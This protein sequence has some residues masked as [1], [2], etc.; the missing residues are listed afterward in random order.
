MKFGVCVQ[1][2]R[3][4]EI[5]SAGFDY[6]EI[7]AASL[8]GENSE[9]DLAPFRGLPI[10]ASNLFFPGPM[11]LYGPDATPYLAYAKRTIER[12]AQIGIKVMV[13]GSGGARRSAEG[14]DAEAR[15][16]D[17]A[18]ELNAVAAGYGIAVAPESLNHKETDV[19][20][21]MGRLAQDLRAHAVGFT[22][23]SYHLLV[24]WDAHFR[25][26]GDS[27]PSAEFWEHE[28]PF[29]PVHVHFANLPRTVP[30]PDD[31]MVKGFVA[32][33]HSLSYDGN[34]S[35]EC[36]IEARPDALREARQHLS[37]LFG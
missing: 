11:R 15:F 8:H 34:V 25:K 30:T 17:I 23:D 33:L 12:A 37:Q 24:D 22:A 4:D 9:F 27:E 13:L 5:L 32:R 1:P 35:L 31:V 28:I 21:K 2:D 26:P 6:I 3:A 18:A 10:L 20:N 29:T 36:T 19:G 7:A 14:I 16:V